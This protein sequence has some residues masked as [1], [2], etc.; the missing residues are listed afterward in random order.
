[1][2]TYIEYLTVVSYNY[3]TVPG[4]E[5]IT[6]SVTL[7]IP[8][9]ET[10]FHLSICNRIKLPKLKRGDKVKLIL[11]PYISGRSNNLKW[12][13]R[14]IILLHDLKVKEIPSEKIDLD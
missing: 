11:H 4:T 8:R 10:K 7:R 3:K 9:T 1:M 14:D 12:T 13:V 5:K 2:F 6:Q